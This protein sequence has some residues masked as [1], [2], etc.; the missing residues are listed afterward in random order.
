M[1]PVHKGIDAF[2][3]YPRPYSS[4]F[5]SRPLSFLFFSQ[6]TRKKGLQ[7]GFIGNIPSPSFPPLNSLRSLSIRRVKTGRKDLLPKP[8]LHGFK[9]TSPRS[10]SPKVGEPANTP[11]P[12]FSHLDSLPS[13]SIRRYEIGPKDLPPRPKLHQFK[14]TS[15]GYISPQL[16]NPALYE[17]LKCA[18]LKGDFVRTHVLVEELVKRRGEVPN[19]RLYHALILANTSPQYGSPTEVMKL[20]DEIEN[21]GLALDPA[22][23]HAV[24]KVAR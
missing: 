3:T 18:A 1:P 4:G 20:L 9:D 21:E 10:A 23:Y 13:F 15:Q 17:E 19:I 2:R 22:I 24:L 14:D 8:K 7:K 11:G 12:S 6:R 5:I 16:G